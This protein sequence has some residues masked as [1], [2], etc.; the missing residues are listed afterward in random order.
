MF[1][2]DEV[3]HACHVAGVLERLP[4][5]TMGVV[6]LLIAVAFIIAGL[7]LADEVV[8]SFFGDGRGV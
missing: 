4:R 2:L 8:G 1:F 6:S 3:M 5:A 7:Q